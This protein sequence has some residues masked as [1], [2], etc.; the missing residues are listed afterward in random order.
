M[1]EQLKKNLEFEATKY[2]NS[3]GFTDFERYVFIDGYNKA[4]EILKEI[5]E[6]E[7][8]YVLDGVK[9]CTVKTCE[10][11]KTKNLHYYPDAE[12]WTCAFC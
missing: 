8:L 2:K 10:V 7:S 1:V 12:C 9:N 4:I 6:V 11:C 5:Q 3:K